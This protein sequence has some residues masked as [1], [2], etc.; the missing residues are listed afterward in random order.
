MNRKNMSAGLAWAWVG[1]GAVVTGAALT[2]ACSTVT[3]DC[4][5]VFLGTALLW[6]L[7]GAAASPVDRRRALGKHRRMGRFASAYTVSPGVT[8]GGRLSTAHRTQP[9]TVPLIHSFG[10]PAT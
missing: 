7:V 3:E 9:A 2:A 6:T 1:I 4:G 10:L 8:A 5:G